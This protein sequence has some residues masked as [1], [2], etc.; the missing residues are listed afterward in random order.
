MRYSFSLEKVVS[1][2]NLQQHNYCVV[3]VKGTKSIFIEA[4]HKSYDIMTYYTELL[5]LHNLSHPNPLYSLA[6]L[7]PDYGLGL[8]YS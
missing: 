1:G 3:C 4:K 8:R 7:G 6:A 2:R 5:E